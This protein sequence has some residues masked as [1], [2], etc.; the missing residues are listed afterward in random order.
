MKVIVVRADFR[1]FLVVLDNDVGFGSLDSDGLV[2]TSATLAADDGKNDQTDEQK[3]GR[4]DDDD[5]S[6][7]AQPM[8]PTAVTMMV[9]MP[10]LS[11]AVLT[12]LS[13][14]MF[15]VFAV[16]MGVWVLTTVFPVVMRVWV[17][18]SFRSFHEDFMVAF[19]RCV[20]DDTVVKRNRRHR[21]TV[22]TFPRDL[23]DVDLSD[24]VLLDFDEF[25]LRHQFRVAVRTGKF[26]DQDSE[27]NG[28][29]SRFL[30]DSSFDFDDGYVHAYRVDDFMLDRVTVDEHAT[31]FQ[32]E[33]Q[34]SRH[35]DV[36]ATVRFLQVDRNHFRL[37]AIR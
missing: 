35:D 18:K 17:R 26:L 24:F 37:V 31:F 30:S 10:V 13:V 23:F 33:M 16:V 9:A 6:A 29:E 25:H 20:M 2:D 11:V 21:Q 27:Q 19:A 34:V 8:E 7:D 1:R 12:M 22:R 3:S 14:A 4:T 28:R 15:S 36:F 32:T 5:L